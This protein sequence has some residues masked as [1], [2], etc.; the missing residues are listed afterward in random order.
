MKT[1]F[2]LRH[3][4]SRSVDPTLDDHDRPLNPRGKQ[5]APAIGRYMAQHDYRP[6][7]ILCSSAERARQ[8]LALVMEQIDVAAVCYEPELYLASA[9]ALLA[10]LRAL[11]DAQTAVAIVGHNPGLGD[12]A[13]ALTRADGPASETA[14]R[15]HLG[16]KFPTGGLAAIQLP[17]KTWNDIGPGAGVLIGFVR[18]RD[19]MGDC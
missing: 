15:T 2:L 17:V 16:A 3:A 14:L 6:Q 19:L 5:A 7:L 13:L 4:K 12:L 11:S 9:E 10:R 1:L 18:P 8:T